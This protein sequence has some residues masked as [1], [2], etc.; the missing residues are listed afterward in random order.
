MYALMRGILGSALYGSGY[1]V[2]LVSETVPEIRSASN[3]NL[4]TIMDLPS[5]E[6]SLAGK[7][8]VSAEAVFPVP[9]APGDFYVVTAEAYTRISTGVTAGPAAVAEEVPLVRAGG[10]QVGLSLELEP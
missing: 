6:A 3:E 8:E 7:R 1:G 9:G 4:F 5:L 10:H 2:T